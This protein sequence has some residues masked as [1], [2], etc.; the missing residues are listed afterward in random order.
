MDEVSPETDIETE[1]EETL[2][3]KRDRL[4]A[5]DE[6]ARVDR[7]PSDVDALRD[8]VKVLSYRVDRHEARLDYIWRGVR[9]LAAITVK[10]GYTAPLKMTEKL[11]GMVIKLLGVEGDGHDD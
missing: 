8:Q 9:R 4:V 7:I 1:P 6:A 11:R 3:Q 2:E 5:E 10:A